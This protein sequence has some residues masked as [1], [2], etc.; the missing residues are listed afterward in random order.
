MVAKRYVAIVWLASLLMG[1]A[2]SPAI[3]PASTDLWLLGEVHDNAEGHRQRSTWLAT[4][5]AGGWRPTIAME[6][7]DRDQQ[8]ALDAALAICADADCILRAVASPQAGWEWDYYRP[9]LQLAVQ[10]HLPIRAAN[11]ARGEVSRVIRSGISAALDADT[12]ARFGADHPPPAALVA[13]QRE[14]IIAGHCHMLPDSSIPG[15]L[16]AQIARDLWMAQ[17]VLDHASHGVVLLAG[18]GH[19]RRDV[20]AAYW[21]Q[22]AAPG[23]VHSVAYLEKGTNY[24]QA[25]FDDVHKVD[26]QPRS[27]PC[28]GLQGRLRG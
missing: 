10:Y 24:P 11:I 25:A 14:E 12:L 13:S 2:T 18:N 15:M 28:A 6:Q 23:R 20:G 7:F 17:T 21:L 1:C 3:P 19:V 5:L 26:A 4:Q 22:Q 9:V 27:D 16:N 8:P